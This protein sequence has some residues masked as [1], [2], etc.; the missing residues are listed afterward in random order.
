MAYDGLMAAAVLA[1]IAGPLAG[2]KIEKISQP[3]PDRMIMQIRSAQ[4]RRKLLFDLSSQ[5]ARVQFTELEYENP[6]NA[7]SFCMLLRKHIQGGRILQVRQHGKE[8]ITELDI[9]TVNEMGYS[10]NKRLIAETMGKHSNLVLLDAQSGK[11]IDSIKRISIDVNRV[12]QIL[13]GVIYEYPPVSNLSNQDGYGPSTRTAIEE[14]AKLPDIPRVGASAEGL[15]CYVYV[16]EDGKPKDFHFFRMPQYAGSYKELVFPT[17]CK[18]MDWFYSHK[19]STNRTSQ[20][21]EDLSRHIGSLI[22][23]SQLKKQRLLEEIQKADEADIYRLKGELLNANLHLARPGDKKVEVT[24]YYDGSRLTI[25][26]DEKLSA[27]KNAQNYYKKYAKLKSSKKEKLAQL[28]ECEKDIEYLS[29]VQAMA[30]NAASGEEVDQLRE[31]LTEQ[32]YVRARTA[33]ARKKKAKPAPRRYELASGLYVLVGRNNTENDLITFKMAQKTDWWFHTKD[34]HGSHVILVCNGTDP[35]PQDMYDA[36]AIAA[37]FSKGRD[38]QNVPVDYAMAKN[39]KK[40]SG[41]RPGMV[42]FYD[43]GTVWIDPKDPEVCKS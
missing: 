40:P 12:R 32:G 38:S 36:A 3:E 21:A 15:A 25:E 24:S 18:G 5:G 22:N 1:E 7:P 33:A 42:I 30:A 28:S 41:A 29:S 27:A 11:I 20:K 2:A 43:N 34:I 9:E 14:G 6:Q 4:G 23:K 16:S 37:W 39:V 35:S 8:R 31:E 13:P 17:L 26:L 10:V 19:L